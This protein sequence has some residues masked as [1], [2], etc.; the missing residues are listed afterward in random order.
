[1]KPQEIA[2]P[3]SWS[4]MNV[5]LAGTGCFPWIFLGLLA[6]LR[7]RDGS[8]L[9]ATPL[10]L[11]S[12]SSFL[13]WK[14]QQ[15]KIGQ[16][17]GALPPPGTHLIY[18]NCPLLI[19]A[20]EAEQNDAN[21][22]SFLRSKIR[23]ALPKEKKVK[24]KKKKRIKEK[25]KNTLLL[26]LKSESSRISFFFKS[27]SGDSEVCTSFC[28]VLPHIQPAPPH[29]SFSVFGLSFVFFFLKIFT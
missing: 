26:G 12:S 1:M 16:Q 6:F 27:H 8:G 14:K 13:P 20:R 22:K 18:F 19:R 2:F 3:T 24:K 28:E 25:T 15:K 4:R 9:K 10:E 11:A 7:E 5:K 29:F 21:G 17:D 23:S